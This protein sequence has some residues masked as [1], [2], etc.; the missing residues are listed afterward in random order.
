MVCW[1]VK[2][3][4]SFCCFI[5]NPEPSFINFEIHEP[6][7]GKIY[8]SFKDCRQFNFFS[9]FIAL[10]IRIIKIFVWYVIFFLNHIALVYILVY[11]TCI[12]TINTKWVLYNDLPLFSMNMVL[13]HTS[14][15]HKKF[16]SVYKNCCGTFHLNHEKSNPIN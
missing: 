9:L 8:F 1:S 13:I 4:Q 10:F 7:K 12:I 15:S 14:F 11:I 2:D 3:V 6:S 16:Y 5:D